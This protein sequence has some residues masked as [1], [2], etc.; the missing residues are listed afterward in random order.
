M[1]LDQMENLRYQTGIDLGT[2]LLVA[3]LQTGVLLISTAVMIP[4]AYPVSSWEIP[5]LQRWEI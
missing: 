5:Q 2:V 1:V 3:L 4:T